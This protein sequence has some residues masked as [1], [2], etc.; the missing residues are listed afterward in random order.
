MPKGID[1]FHFIYVNL[2]FIAQVLAMYFFLA[3]DDIKKNWPKYRCNPVYMPLSNNIEADFT[4]CIQN[5]QTNFMGYLLEP[6]TYIM[7]N[8]SALGDGLSVDLNFARN[9]I[10]NIRGFL[11]EIVDGIFG[12][13]VN[14][15]TEFQKIIIGITDLIGKLIGIVVTMMYVMDGSLKTMQSTWNGPPG[16]MVQVMGNCFHP[17]TQ[18]KRKDGSIV[19]MKDLDLGDI[20]ENGS[21]VRAIM[22]IEN[23]KH[24]HKLYKI[25]KRGV[26]ENDIYV[27]GTHMIEFNGTF[28]EVKNHPLSVE[29]IGVECDWFSCLITDNHLIKIG[30]QVFWDWEDYIIKK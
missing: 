14:L 19:F 23:P 22:K 5:M 1:W 20:L 3:L 29:Q 7:A 26:N 2:G 10:A 18:I 30:K 15:I 8:V 6:L 24:I 16:Q 17:E 4:Y 12:V 21:Q 28:V 11:S 25:P 27:T 9:M 13:F